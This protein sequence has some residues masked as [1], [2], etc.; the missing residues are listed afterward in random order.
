MIIRATTYQVAIQ[1]YA[2]PFRQ[3]LNTSHGTWTVREGIIITLRSPDGQTGQGEIAPLTWFGSESLAAAL[4]FCQSLQGDITLEQ[5]FA[6]PDCLP[7]CQFAFE[8]AL[9]SLLSHDRRR[10][11]QATQER[12]GIDAVPPLQIAALLPTGQAA[13]TQWQK[14]YTQGHRTFKWKIGVAPIADE[15]NWFR[16]LHQQLP[17]NCKLRLDA[18]AGLSLAESERW[19]NDFETYP[20]EYLEQPLSVHQFSAMQRLSSQYATLIAL[21]ESIAQLH[22]IQAYQQRGWTGIYIIKPAIAGSPQR[23]MKFLRQ[24]KITA[25]FSSV[26]ETEIGYAAALRLAQA[27]QANARAF[28]FGTS[29]WWY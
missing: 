21:D 19:L 27:L 12:Q 25:V 11:Q 24:Q 17:K 16:Q 23:L 29:N 26:F 1:L 2:R 8:T 9:A 3:A 22:Q 14:L 15:R 5:I 7:C 20:I 18:N 4:Q 6:I 13:I 10:T 28:G